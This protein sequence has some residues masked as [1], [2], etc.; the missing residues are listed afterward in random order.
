MHVKAGNNVKACM[1][2]LLSD[3]RFNGE[4]KFKEI[5]S[6]M[7]PT[8]VKDHFSQDKTPQVIAFLLVSEVKDHYFGKRA[9]PTKKELK[10]RLGLSLN[11]ALYSIT[12]RGSKERLQK[13]KKL[14]HDSY[15]I[16]L[17]KYSNDYQKSA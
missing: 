12:S 16:A 15:V 10:S 14:I 1:D 4:H 13:F 5:C 3:S 17:E 7:K 9:P 11:S 2:I 6:F 8:I